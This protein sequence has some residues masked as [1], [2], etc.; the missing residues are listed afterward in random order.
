MQMIP[1]QRISWGDLNNG[2]MASICETINKEVSKSNGQ[3]VSYLGQFE[4]SVQM[5]AFG[6]QHRCWSYQPT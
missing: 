1:V 3:Y 2:E 5:R 6:E 4:I